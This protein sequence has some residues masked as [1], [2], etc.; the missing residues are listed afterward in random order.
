M[1]PPGG[2]AV[3]PPLFSFC[4]RWR[5]RSRANITSSGPRVTHDGAYSRHLSARSTRAAGFW[6]DLCSPSGVRETVG[7]GGRVSGGGICLLCREASREGADGI[8]PYERHQRA[9]RSRIVFDMIIVP[10]PV[11]TLK[12]SLAC[13]DFF[14]CHY[15]RLLLA[16]AGYSDWLTILKEF[17][18]KA[19]CRIA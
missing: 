8:P 11:I 1:V 16:S 6:G 4:Q 17:W 12:D 18:R 15:S 19:S 10:Q 7:G 14:A 9:V 2:D 3:H 5:K 13:C